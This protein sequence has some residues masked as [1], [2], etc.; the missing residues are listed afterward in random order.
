MPIG[1][2]NTNCVIAGHR[3]WN[4]ARYFLDIE[5]LSVGDRVFIDNLWET[6]EY[7]VS[8]IKIINPDD[9]DAVK[10]QDGK[11]MVTLFTC[12]PYWDSTYRYAVFCTRVN[13]DDSPAPKAEPATQV[14]THN[15]NGNKSNINTDNSNVRI[16]AEQVSYFVIPLLLLILAFVLLLK[17]RR[18]NKRLEKKH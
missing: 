13:N 6:L 5:T 1:G 15:D 12:H 16:K 7:S 14:V 9:I 4:G 8:E 11:D 17:N 10:I 2:I 18:K 3:G